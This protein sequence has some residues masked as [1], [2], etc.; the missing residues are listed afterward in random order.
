MA[1][2]LLPLTHPM[3]GSVHAVLEE[4]E[5]AGQ[6]DPAY[7]NTTEKRA[8]LLIVTAAVEQLRAV[9]VRLLANAEDVAA[10]TGARNVAAWAELAMRVDRRETARAARLGEALERRWPRLAAAFVEG[11]ATE[12]QATV[13]VRALD[14]LPERL[15]PALRAQAEEYLVE[16]AAAFAPRDLE[17]LANRVLDVLAPEIAEEEERRRLEAEERAARRSTS[18]TMH[19]R[20]DGS[21]DIRIR[22]PD[23]VAARLKVYLESLTSPRQPG[24]PDP[25]D[26]QARL[27]YPRR[28]GEAFC[29]LLERLPAKVLPQHGG[30]ST[31]VMVTIPFEQL[32]S[33][34]GAADLGTGGRITATEARRLACT[35]DI[36]PIVLGGKSEVLDLGRARRLFSPAQRKAMAVRDRRCRT[37]GCSIPAAWCEAHHLR[38]WS[39]G[40]RTDLED[41]VSLCSWHHHRAHDPRYTAD[42]LPNGDYRFTRRT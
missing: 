35:A 1:V 24:R 39:Q 8:A 34:L 6:H 37:E 28:L 13:L 16:Q 40:G 21:S 4:V 38:L 32:R 12:A 10:D 23:H 19:T 5:R 7:L 29:A 36:I 18:L 3:L 20:G 2:D 26:E 15:G 27:P 30:T 9:Q 42:R 25:N 11:R 41:G 22:V 14:S 31:S 33:G 17:R